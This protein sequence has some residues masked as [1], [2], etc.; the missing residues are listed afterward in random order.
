MK[1]GQIQVYIIITYTYRSKEIEITE[2]IRI[3]SVSILRNRGKPEV[4]NYAGTEILM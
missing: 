3:A 2:L 4:G 1:L